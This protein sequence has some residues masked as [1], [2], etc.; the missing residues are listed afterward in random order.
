MQPQ[1]KTH[2]NTRKNKHKLCTQAQHTWRKLERQD[3]Q[4]THLG[5]SS[6]AMVSEELELGI[7]SPA[8]TPNWGPPPQPG[9]SAGELLPS[10]A[11][12]WGSPPQPE[13]PASSTWG[14]PP[15][16]LS[17]INWGNQ[18]QHIQHHQDIMN[19]I[20][21]RESSRKTYGNSTKSQQQLKSTQQN[22]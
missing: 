19:I 14:P 4:H 6:P 16:E 22:H 1:L 18:H 10:R 11:L 13:L 9:R 12:R 8:R 2:I 7:S 15:Q 20:K 5:T 17:K 21:K 3:S